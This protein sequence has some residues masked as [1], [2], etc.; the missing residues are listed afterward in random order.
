[1]I[2]FF[3]LLMLIGFTYFTIGTVEFNKHN[4][5]SFKDKYTHSLSDPIN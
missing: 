3:D 4:K 5:L 2:L 1:M